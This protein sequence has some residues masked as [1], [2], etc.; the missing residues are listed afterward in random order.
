M[1]TRLI[2]V[3]GCPGSGKSSTAQFLGRQLQRAG[4]TC[5]WYYEEERPHPLAALKGIDRSKGYREF[6]TAALIRWRD[7]VRRARRSKEITIV[8]SHF[9]QNLITPLLRANV[10]PERIGKVVHKMAE[11]V[12]PLRPMMVY[13]H[14]PDYATTMRRILDERGAR[15]EHYIRLSENSAYGK[16]HGLEG[17]DGLVQ[18]WVDTRTLM[19]QLI[20]DLE[21]PTLSIDNSAGDWSAY[22]EQIGEFLSTPFQPGPAL[23]ADALTAYA[24][25]Y[26]Y[27]S[28]TAPRRAAGTTRFGRMNV[29]RRVGGLPRSVALHHQKEVEFTISVEQGEL[30]LRDYGWL[31]PTNRLIPIDKDIFDIRSWPF[32]LHFEREAGEIVAATRQSETTRWQITG[33]R[34]PRL[35]GM[36][37]T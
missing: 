12:T 27:R 13:L 18:N 15:I 5:R 31:W 33:Q 11:F 16:R 25:T 4:H 28:N 7:F 26:T 20:E 9:F 23:S 30:V 6:G 24:G 19:E 10:K 8:E 29:N 22:L 36:T 21:F 37:D 2:L 34:Y 3:E 14:Q 17:F 1:D 32:Q 35:A